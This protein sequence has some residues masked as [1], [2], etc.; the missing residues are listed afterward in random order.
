MKKKVR[1]ET[2]V[3][4][5]EYY[6]ILK[7]ENSLITIKVGTYVMESE[8][9]YIQY[10]LIFKSKIIITNKFQIWMFIQIWLRVI[11]GKSMKIN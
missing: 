9:T 3:H 1:K 10:I 2:P 4:A 8:T 6:C 5:G 11:A 7:R